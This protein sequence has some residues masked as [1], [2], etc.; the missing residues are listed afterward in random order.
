MQ[1]H[2][3]YYSLQHL[4]VE[5]E[6]LLTQ[7]RSAASDVVASAHEIYRDLVALHEEFSEVAWDSRAVVILSDAPKNEKNH[8]FGRAGDVR[9]GAS[10]DVTNVTSLSVSC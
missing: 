3:L 5:V 4:R 6:Q 1:Q 9:F 10:D 2:D 8:R 7:L